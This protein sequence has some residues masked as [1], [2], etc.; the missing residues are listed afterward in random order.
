M[1]KLLV[2]VDMVNGFIN[3]GAMADPYINTITP[4]VKRLMEEFRENE[5]GDIIAFCDSH[6]MESEEFKDYP[7]HCLK[8]TRESEMIDEL[9]CFKKDITVFEKDT[10]N[11]FLEEEY[12]KYFDSHK[13]EYDEI[14]VVGCCSDICVLNYVTSQKENIDQEKIDITITVPKN[15]IET[16]EGPGHNRRKANEYAIATMLQQGIHVVDSYNL[17]N[18]KERKLFF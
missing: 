13:E 1:K 10:T 7:I 11:G 6:T 12:R 14:I 16:Y 2:V 15:A 9:Q 18:E 3:E 17:E 8:G 4:E 5:K